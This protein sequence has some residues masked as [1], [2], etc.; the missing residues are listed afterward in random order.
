MSLDFFNSELSVNNL[1][2]MG[3]EPYY[4]SQTGTEV[5]ALRYTNI[6]SFEGTPIDLLVQNTTAYH[7]NNAERNG[8]SGQFGQINLLLDRKTYFRFCFLNASVDSMTAYV[9]LTEVTMTFYDFDQPGA[10]CRA[11]RLS[12]EAQQISHHLA[13]TSPSQSYSPR[14]YLSTGRARRGDLRRP[15]PLL[16]GGHR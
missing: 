2:C 4:S 15:K 7:P 9:P 14:V 8:I 11:T 10:V 16:A 1:G 5:C 6:G 3:P 13:T 12:S